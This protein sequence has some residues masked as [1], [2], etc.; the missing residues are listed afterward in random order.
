MNI[1]PSVLSQIMQNTVAANP[2]IT[3]QELAENTIE[4]L[5]DPIHDVLETNQIEDLSNLVDTINS[6]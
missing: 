1:R 5:T 6:L 2:E 4:A 3:R